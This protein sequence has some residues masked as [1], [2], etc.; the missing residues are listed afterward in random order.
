MFIFPILSGNCLANRL[1][2]RIQEFW[3]SKFEDPQ[4]IENVLNKDEFWKDKIGSEEYY[5]Y[6]YLHKSDE[7]KSINLT[8]SENATRILSIHAS[9]GN[10]CE[11]VFVLGLNE[12][13]LNIFSKKTGNL[14]YDSLLHVAITRQKKSLYVGIAPAKDDIMYKFKD[15]DIERD[16]SIRP[17]IE[18]IKC[19][20]K[21]KKITSYAFEDNENFKQIN[22][23]IIVPN[24]YEKTLPSDTDRKGLI[25]WGHHV[26]RYYVFLYNFTVNIHNNETVEI[27][28]DKSDRDTSQHLQF[29]TILKKLAQK[30]IVIC[31]GYKNYYEILKDIDISNSAHYTHP[32][33]PILRLHPSDKTKYYK[34]AEILHVFMK[35]IQ[36]KLRKELQMNKLPY[37]CPLETIILYHMI[38]IGSYAEITIM[39][40]FS[41]MY[42]YEE[43]YTSLN[44]DI[45]CECLCQKCF[46]TKSCSDIKKYKDISESITNHYDNTQKL[47]II[48]ENYKSYI[49]EKIG[50]VFT[51]NMF[52]HVMTSNENFIMSDE[53]TLIAHSENYVIFFII[54]PQFNKLNFNEIIFDGIYKKYMLYGVN[55][56]TKNYSRYSG[57][58][59]ISCLLT[60]DSVAPIF[61]DFDIEKDNVVVKESLKSSLLKMFSENHELVFNFYNYCKHRKPENMNS[62]KYTL[63]QIEKQTNEKFPK[64]IY[65]FFYDLNMELSKTKEKQ[66]VL[67]KVNNKE[68]FL[69][70]LAN[71]LEEAINEYLE[72]G[73]EECDY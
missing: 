41:I 53:H 10:G 20:V 62:I 24:E 30:K 19:F 16:E 60:L 8:E 57:K 38:Q 13:A 14:V 55:A 40:I 9:K 35:N 32:I 51:Y 64:Y 12:K 1:E 4:Y 29:I 66:F 33:I 27:I 42:C 69:I 7:G 48:Y 43:C 36:M 11:V 46:Q 37:L 2:T 5:K 67:E 34:Y 39:D 28:N 47:K 52:H 6:I 73:L 58:K 72:I 22:D 31:D 25:D 17:R 68:I 63:Q 59:I 45:G 23:S 70:E 54:K 15:I 71:K 56:A 65:E 49:S 21:Y 44:H 61:Y 50:E 26:I 3:I 18:D